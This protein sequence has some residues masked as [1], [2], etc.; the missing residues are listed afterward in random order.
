MPIA[1]RLKWYLESHHVDYEVVPHAHTSA[2]L[3]SA[4]VAHV[5]GGRVAKCVLL[6]D[7]RGYIMAIVPASCRLDLHEIDR[8]LER[9]LA[10]ATE[11]E[12]EDIF[13]GC[14]PGAI[15]AVGAAFN[16]PAAI[17]LSLFRLPDVYFDEGDHAGLVHV[18]GAAFKGLVEGSA[19]GHFGRP[20]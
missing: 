20:Q 1:H 9:H 17:D 12:L 15:P 14:E 2:M 10:L 18:S 13:V 8:T 11:P 6:E 16:V 19:S 4:R 7:D 5:P 3:E